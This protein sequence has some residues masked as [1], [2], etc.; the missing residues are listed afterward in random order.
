MGTLITFISQHISLSPSARDRE[1]DDY[2][3][4]QFQNQKRPQQ[5]QQQ[6]QL[7]SCFHQRERALQQFPCEEKHSF[8]PHYQHNLSTS[9]SYSIP[10]SLSSSPSNSSPSSAYT[11]SSHSSLSRATG[12]RSLPQDSHMHQYNYNTYSGNNKHDYSYHRRYNRRQ[13]LKC[14]TSQQQESYVVDDWMF[15]IAEDDEYHNSMSTNMMRASPQES[16]ISPPL[17]TSTV[18]L[19]SSFSRKNRTQ[20]G[21][22]LSMFSTASR[23]TV[24]FS[25]AVVEHI[26]RTTDH[27]KTSIGLLPTI[28]E[29][30]LSSSSAS[31]SSSPSST[32]PSS[33]K[34]LSAKQSLMRIAHCSKSEDGWCTQKAGQY[35]QRYAST[36]RSMSIDGR[37][38][39]RM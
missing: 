39:R 4:H 17:S 5:Q 38:S 24:T 7:S 16:P 34:K 2:F 23:S 29:S 35:T 33:S 22:V 10:P 1:R 19:K 3:G 32:S 36:P 12:F 21:S 15:G 9:P 18:S 28:S 37:R 26:V 8:N 11:S 25:P 6:S 13:A 27:P 31:V 14:Y 20:R 30:T